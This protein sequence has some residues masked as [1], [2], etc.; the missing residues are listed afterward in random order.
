MDKNEEFAVDTSVVI[1]GVLTKLVEEGKIRGSIVI[2]KAVIAE[3]EH[4]ANYNRETGYRGLNELK[5][6]NELAKEGKIKIVYTGNRPGEAQIKRARSGE[7]DAMIR[8]MAWDR[9]ATLVTGDIVQGETALATGMN[10]LMIREEKKIDKELG[11]EK[12]FDNTTMSIHLKEDVLPYVKRGVPGSFE[13]LPIGDKELTREKMKG[14]IDEIILKSHFFNDAFIEIDRKY[15]TIVQYADIRI[16]IT[17]PPFSDGLEITAVRPLVKLELEDYKLDENIV[18]RF[19]KKAEGL[20]VAGP[21]GSGKTTFARGLANFYEEKGKIVKTVESPRD[22]NLKPAITQ[23]SKN[24]GSSSEIHDILL[25]SRPDY[26]IFDE[27]RDTKDFK[28]YSDL[29]LSGIGMVGVLHSTAAIDAIQ[30]FIGRLELGVIPS[31]L[32]TVIFIEG[33]QVKQVL[34]LLMT[35]KVPTG[36]IEADLSRP[37]IEVRDFLTKELRY[38]MYTYG[39]ETVVIPIKKESKTGITKIVEESVENK[40]KHL[41]PKNVQSGVEFVGNNSII[42]RTDDKGARKIIG[43]EGRNVQN[44]EKELGLRIDVRTDRGYEQKELIPEEPKTSRKGVHVDYRLREDSTYYYFDLKKTSKGKTV[45]FFSGD[46]FLFDAVV[47]K[48]G[49]IRVAKRGEV[50]ERLEAIKGANGLIKLYV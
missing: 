29:R 39:E 28:L 19:E 15:S 35:V 41:L 33:G 47:S 20:L 45:R 5:R 30:R 10:V 23:Y 13:F 17:R 3:I 9:E 6:I 36:M 31:V 12:Y 46:E 34:E 22:L 27:V 50:G 49:T 7:I 32:D 26:T 42:I 16:V 37:V 11:I 21:P 18:S 25:L 48:K 40:L 2:H 8:D 1:E 4:Q 14:L 24:F 43:R 38:E 44:L